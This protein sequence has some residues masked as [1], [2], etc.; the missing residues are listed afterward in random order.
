MD[1]HLI[2]VSSKRQ[3]TAFLLKLLVHHLGTALGPSKHFASPKNIRPSPLHPYLQI[4]DSYLSDKCS[5]NEFCTRWIRFVKAHGCPAEVPYE[6]LDP[7]FS[8][9]DE[10]VED[11]NERCEWEVG[12][13]E[14]LACVKAARK[15]LNV[16]L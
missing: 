5:G 9:A 14:L 15:S 13:E 12:P 6:I 7:I 10:Y 16:F 3:R 2:V 11:E 1:C 8:A 4:L